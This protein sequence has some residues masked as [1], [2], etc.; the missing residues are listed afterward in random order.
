MTYILGVL[1]IAYF[2]KGY[3]FGVF[4]SVLG[5]MAYHFIFTEPYYTLMAYSPEYPV[6]FIIM[7]IVALLTS[8]LTAQ[9]KR[10][11][12]RVESRE[13]RI[14]ILHQIEK[15]LLATNSKPK[16]IKAAAKDVS[17]VFSASVLIC[18]A[19]DR[20]GPCPAEV[21]DP[22]GGHWLSHGRRINMILYYADWTRWTTFDR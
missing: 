18:A 11:T 12:Q 10:E 21:Y 7:L 17:H 22:R 13:R 19:K 1:L 4:G 16:L 2:T 8:A 14:Q 3:W 6:T 9:V 5:V 15:D 20:G